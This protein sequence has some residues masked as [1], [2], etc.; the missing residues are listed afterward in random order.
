MAE[1]AGIEPFLPANANPMMVH[2]FGFY[3]VKAFELRLRFFSPR[4]PSSPLESSPVLEI[5]W[6]RIPQ[7]L[8]CS[9]KQAARSHS[10]IMVSYARTSP[11]CSCPNRR[12]SEN[13]AGIVPLALL[14]CPVSHSSPDR[15]AI[16]SG[17]RSRKGTTCR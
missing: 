14:D 1:A 4:V 15:L 9:D 7:E 8:Q 16:A 3:G 17:D 6:R 10:Q 12:Y 13:T 11:S 2:D 5:S